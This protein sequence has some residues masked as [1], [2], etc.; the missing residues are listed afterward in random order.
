LVLLDVC[1]LSCYIH[2][3]RIRLYA[4][5][6]RPFFEDIEPANP[7]VYLIHN[8]LTAKEADQLVSTMDPLLSTVTVEDSL[9]YSDDITYLQN[10]QTERAVQWQ[11]LVSS[12]WSP[13][14]KAMVD[15]IDQVT[16]FPVMHTSD[17]IVDK[18]SSGR[19]ERHYDTV[20]RAYV[21]LAT[22][23]IFLN[24]HDTALW[25]FPLIKG[26]NNNNNNGRTNTNGKDGAGEIHIRPR[27]GMAIVH[28]NTDV[29]D[30]RLDPYAVHALDMNGST[31]PL[32]VARKIILPTPVGRRILLPLLAMANGGRL[33]RSLSRWHETLLTQYG[34]EDGP[35]YF[36]WALVIGPS[37]ILLVLLT[38]IVY[39]LV[40]STRRRT[41]TPAVTTTTTNGTTATT[42]KI[43][44]K[45][46][47][48]D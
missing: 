1:S 4:G 44:D 35:K 19:W 37:V 7:T 31:T 38:M 10:S 17:F 45:R 22:I 25:K 14:H 18:I 36:D 23:T 13:Q 30:Q 26:H 29:E 5:E 21:P 2:I 34:P 28:H 46:S 27:K 43:R 20:V 24:H 40:V 3:F 15:R 41:T 9:N 32:Y 8:L 48:K 6:D 16:G 12:L 42:T 39:G 11:G 33:P 47:K